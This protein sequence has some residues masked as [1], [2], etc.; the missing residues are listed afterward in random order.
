M[1]D[2]STQTSNAA[3]RERP[4]QGAALRV[5]IITPVYNARPYLPATWRSLRRQTFTDWEWVVSDDGSTDGSR[6][7]LEKLAARDPRVRFLEGSHQRRA[8]AANRAVRHARANILCLLD[9]DDIWHPEKLQRQIEFLDKNKHYDLSHTWAREFWSRDLQLPHGTPTPIVWPRIDTPPDPIHHLLAVGQPFCV[10]SLAIRRAA[11]DALGG[12]NENLLAHDDLEFLLR[13][14]Q[15]H[16]IGRTPGYLVK[17]RLSLSAMSS[18]PNP[19]KV[20][21]LHRE[22][23]CSEIRKHSAWNKYLANYHLKLAE[24]AMEGRLPQSPRSLLAKA[25]WHNPMAKNRWPLLPLLLLP[26]RCMLPVYKA[27]KRLQARLFSGK[28]T[29]HHMA[30][31]WTPGS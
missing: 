14:L 22:L 26:R 31:S 21:R 29:A 10:S 6:E 28:V 13:A 4:Q 20:L 18:K 27:L 11:W 30:G 12:M 23:Q 15:H 2:R 24:H 16:S 5:S 1:T 8:A 7:W 17:Y 19:E 25:L 3:P 9:A